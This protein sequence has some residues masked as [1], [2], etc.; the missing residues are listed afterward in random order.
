VLQ[1]TFLNATVLTW[2]VALG[3][4]LIAIVSVFVL[5]RVGLLATVVSMAVAS[6]LVSSSLTTDTSA[7]YAGIGYGVVLVCA[8]IMSYG[9][10]TALAGR[11]VMSSVG[12]DD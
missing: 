11:P 3:T 7:W 4:A 8:V 12:I 1:N 6:W 2:T 10:R 5:F 9:L